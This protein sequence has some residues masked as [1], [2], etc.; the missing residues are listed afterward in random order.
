MRKF[1]ILI[2]FLLLG[3]LAQA[4]KFPN[5]WQSDPKT[6]AE[7]LATS[8]PI[9]G[10]NRINS[11]TETI[12]TYVNGT[13]VDTGSGAV[14]DGSETKITNGTNTTVTGTGTIG[15]PYQINTPLQNLSSVL[16]QGNT[17]N[18]NIILS[19][20]NRL[21]IPNRTTN[22]I[23]QATVSGSSI[24]FNSLGQLYVALGNKAS[25]T[26]N[27][28]QDWQL[29]SNN[30]ATRTYTL[31]DASG[32][33]AL[34]SDFAGTGD[35]TAATAF[36]S[37]NRL[38]KS[39]G[40][41]KGVQSTGIIVYDNNDIDFSFGDLGNARSLTTNVSVITSSLFSEE[42]QLTPKDLVPTLE[43]EGNMYWDDSENRL[44]AHDGT[45][46]KKFLLEGDASGGGIVAE[47][48]ITTA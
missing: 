45:G 24:G 14:A 5:G 11:E 4:Q 22:L 1:K 39:D 43:A 10:L 18:S 31:P 37:D 16:G 47:G 6:T 2:A 8:S 15:S 35:V 36:G 20:D 29:A 21:F 41:G 46:F 26:P 32:T 48:T 23:S 38:I 33:V 13:W 42:L 9:E 7:I 25:G 19:A 3:Y 12:W 27:T 28:Y 44:I 34:T 30:S 17:A 40:T